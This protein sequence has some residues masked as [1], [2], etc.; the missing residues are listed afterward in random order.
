MLSALT[1]TLLLAISSLPAVVPRRKYAAIGLV[2]AFGLWIA[3]GVYLHNDLAKNL[4]GGDGPAFFAIAFLIGL[5]QGV[6]LLSL[7]GRVLAEVLVW[8]IAPSNCQRAIPYLLGIGTVPV[9]L[10]VLSGFNP[11]LVGLAAIAGFP[12][13]WMGMA[14][15]LL[16]KRASRQLPLRA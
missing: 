3:V 1:F 11:V 13:L 16:L 10:A 7:A 15:A 2:L 12:L 14:M 8:R 6:V 4:S 5:G 9:V